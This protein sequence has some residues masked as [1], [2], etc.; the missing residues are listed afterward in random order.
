MMGKFVG[1]DVVFRG[2][3][4]AAPYRIRLADDQTSHEE[5]TPN[6][7]LGRR[8]ASKKPMVI[9]RCQAIRM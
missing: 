7:L 4:R 3:C 9:S 1:Y 5:T 8:Q 6:E 2:P